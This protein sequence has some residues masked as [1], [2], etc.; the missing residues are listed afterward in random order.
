MKLA[1]AMWCLQ[2]LVSGVP[3]KGPIGTPRNIWLAFKRDWIFHRSNKDGT[4]KAVQWA[5]EPVVIAQVPESNIGKGI[6]SNWQNTHVGFLSH[7]MGAIMARKDESR[8]LPLPLP[9]KIVN[10]K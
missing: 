10:Q 9:R 8:P 1:G 3:V 6:R 5:R 4:R 2:A 7:G